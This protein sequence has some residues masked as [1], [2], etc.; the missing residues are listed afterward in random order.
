MRT[1]VSRNNGA[2]LITVMLVIALVS[3]IAVN[4]GSKL[5]M[6]ITR[7]GNLQQAEQ[8]Y[9]MWLSAEEV[10]K[11]AL[12]RELNENDG[13]ANNQ[14]GWASRTG[15]FPVEGGQ[16]AARVRD[17]SSCFNVNSL[18]TDDED[19]GTL[20]RRKRQYKALLQSVELDEY[21]AESLTDS[22]VDWLDEDTQLS[23]SNGAE[24]PDYQGL[25]KPYLAANSLLLDISELRMVRGYSQEIVR[26]L[27]P[28]VC[29]IPHETALAINVN[30]LKEEQAVLLTALTEGKM[31]FQDAQS[32][33]ANRPEAG[34]ESN[35]EVSELEAI[36][37]VKAELNAELS[38]LDVESEYFQLTAYIQWGEVE[39]KARSVLHVS[40]GEV[41]TLY[42]AMGE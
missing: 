42:R 7:M 30:T 5:Q 24:D 32:L 6:Q 29:A 9:W 8:S 22:L 23:G 2:A 25:P 12:K 34:Y 33:L 17:L 20:E 18:V 40:N 39:M 16:I 10:L 37:T 38:E 13:V 1:K 35:D 27:R 14:Q 11:E 3:V 41:T 31:S 15:P 36:S 21:Q 19:P 26:K 4:L 28:Y